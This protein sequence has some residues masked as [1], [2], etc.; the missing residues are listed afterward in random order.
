MSTLGFLALALTIAASAFIQGATGM[1][2]AMV[3]APVVALIDPRLIPVMLLVLMIPLNGYIAWRERG[4]IDWRGVRWIS[5]GRFAGTFGGLWVLLLVTTRGLSLIIGWT[6][7]LAV[8]AALLAPAFHPGRSALGAVGV[9]TGI[10]E[11]ATGVGGPPL[12]LA[13]Q[14]GPGPT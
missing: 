11:T 3:A 14:H 7:L 10:T 12:A 2:F 8:A 5:V 1:G 13:Y 4:A 6:T 9:I